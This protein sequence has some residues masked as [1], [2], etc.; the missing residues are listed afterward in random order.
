MPV[1]PSRLLQAWL[2]GLLIVPHLKGNLLGEGGHNEAT[3]LVVLRHKL[4][5]RLPA[6]LASAVSCCLATMVSP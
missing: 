1:Q 6:A 5:E 4:H 2:Q 3:G